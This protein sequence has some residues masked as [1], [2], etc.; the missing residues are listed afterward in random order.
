[1][2]VCV[3]APQL[4]FM[5]GEQQLFFFFKNNYSLSQLPVYVHTIVPLHEFAST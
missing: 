4:L 2:C 5:E 1:M 3:R